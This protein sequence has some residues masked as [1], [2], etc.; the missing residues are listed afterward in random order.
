MKKIISAMLS[1]LMIFSFI[2]FVKSSAAEA[3]NVALGATYIAP[4]AIRGYTASLTDGIVTDEFEPG[5]VDFYGLFWN[6]LAEDS[7]CHSEYESITIDLGGYYDINE[8]RIHAVIEHF[9]YGI[10]FPANIKGM[11]SLNSSDKIQIFTYM[12][13]QYNPGSSTLWLEA[14][15]QGTTR[16]VII[17]IPKPSMAHWIILDEIEVYGEK[18]DYV[19][20]DNHEGYG[21]NL[22]LNRGYQAP[23][24]IRGY[25]AS[26]TDGVIADNFQPATS[27]WYGLFC[28]DA[29]TDSNAPAGKESIIIDLGNYYDLTRVALHTASADEYAV[30]APLKVEIF[31]CTT[32][33]EGFTSIGEI[34]TEENYGV[35]WLKADIEAQRAR[36]VRFDIILG[37]YWAMLD[38]I[39][40]YG[41]LSEVGVPYMSGDISGDG[42]IDSL[43]YIALKR[44]CFDTYQF[45]ETQLDSADINQDGEISNEDYV[46][47]KRHCFGT[48]VIKD[49]DSHE[50]NIVHEKQEFTTDDRL[51]DLSHVDEGNIAVFGNSF[52]W[53]SQICEIFNE[54]SENNGQ[55]TQLWDY[56]HRYLDLFS[57]EG[58]RDLKN[59]GITTVL[60][61]GF[62]SSDMLND[63]FT[64]YTQCDIVGIE[65]VIF[66]AHNENRMLLNG[67][68]VKYPDFY[69]LDWKAE[70]DMLIESGIDRWDMCV[71]D[72]HDHSTPLAGYVGAHMIYRAVF[73]EIPDSS[74]LSDTIAYSYIK[75]KL[76][77]YVETGI[78]E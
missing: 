64:I 70:I 14:D 13:S 51:G 18:S 3:E 68:S 20:E 28:N 47:L 41:L 75:T 29:A 40:V 49:N 52:I 77:N 4:E 37:N 22:V 43:D 66:P 78:I 7:N 15:V 38:E 67:V 74:Q 12:Q 76:G 10:A 50:F 34:E 32:P 60:I 45:S 26:L 25:N 73:G 56:S 16:Y 23:E 57:L 6:D 5:S 35:F 63:I 71:D 62:Y 69:V 39:E 9:Q 8:I 36:Y 17:N 1:I 33:E 46:A 2:P 61:C 72:E 58:V 27:D 11:I 24:A 19:P 21:E 48:Y 54:L 59:E 31:A 42:E 30:S 44:Y 53:T 65:L 55:A